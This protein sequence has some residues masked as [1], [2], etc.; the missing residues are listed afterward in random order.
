VRPR[1]DARVFLCAQ[2]G[3]DL[4]KV[5]HPLRDHTGPFRKGGAIRPRLSQWHQLVVLAKFAR[6]IRQNDLFYTFS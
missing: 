4:L 6:I 3:V 5:H 1:N 2:F